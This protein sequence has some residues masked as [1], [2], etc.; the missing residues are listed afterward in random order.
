MTVGNLIKTL[1]DGKNYNVIVDNSVCN[2]FTTQILQKEIYSIRF[3]YFETTTHVYVTT[4][5]AHEKV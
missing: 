3:E 2:W 1:S 5:I 4:V